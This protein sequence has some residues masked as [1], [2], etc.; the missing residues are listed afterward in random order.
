MKNV[1]ITGGAGFIGSHCAVS[2]VNSGYNPIIIDNFSKT[3]QNV[4]K[5]LEII[6]NKKITFYKTD[7]RDKKK[8]NL[9]FKRHKC[10]SVIHCAGFKAV[11][12]SVN[13][14]ISY[15]DNNISSTISLLEC[16]KENNVFKII[17]S[18]SCT[19]YNDSETLPWNEN[20]KIGDTK[21]PY[22][23]SKYIIERILMDLV[24]FDAR[25]NIN[26]ARY[27]NAIGNHSSGLI[28]EN[29]NGIPNFLIPYIIK[30]VQ[31]KLPVLKVFGKNYKTKDG[32]CVRDFV[33]VMDVADGHVAMLKSNKQNKDLK[34]YNFGTGKGSSVLEIIKTFEKQTGK[35]VLYKF[36]K[37]RKGD[38]AVSY[39]S[40]KKAINELNW[41]IKYDLNQAMID[42]K[43]I[44][45][46]KS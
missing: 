30:V 23:T 10:Y 43:K 11:G 42:I 13:K 14:P 37:K 22:G 21:N 28:K 19:V 20:S 41:K 6:T 16:M 5:N 35:K 38:V 44:I 31:K 36:T 45:N 12:E 24:K 40:P 8:I 39:C 26:I 18:S 32:T 29:T 2:L 3:N 4:I 9:I 1:F 15:F 34:V 17:F 25:W 27:F 33:H 7:L 46:K